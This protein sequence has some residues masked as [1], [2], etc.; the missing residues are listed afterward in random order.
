MDGGSDIVALAGIDGAEERQRLPMIAADTLIR[1]PRLARPLAAMARARQIEPSSASR[2]ARALM[3][4]GLP[5]PAARITTAALV[6]FPEDAS[7]RRD[8]LKQLADAGDP[9][10]LAKFVDSMVAARSRDV[11]LLWRMWCLAEA[12]PAR[13]ARIRAWFDEAAGYDRQSLLRAAQMAHRA[14]EPEHAFG[15]HTAAIDDPDAT[16]D[17]RRN[18]IVDGTDYAFSSEIWPATIPFI[19]DAAASGALAPGR[20]DVAEAL[21]LAG[22]NPLPLAPMP[23][24]LIDDLMVSCPPS[25]G[26]PPSGGGVLMVA[27]SLGCGGMERVLAT[28][29]CELRRRDRA[30]SLALSAFVPDDPR[31]AF[32]LEQSGMAAD[33]IH[34]LGGPAPVEPVALLP[35]SWRTEGA[36][37]HAIVRRERPRLL[38]AWNDRL[39]I[40]AALAGLRAGCPRLLIHVHHMRPTRDPDEALASQP[41][42]AMLRRLAERSDV[43]LL[44]CAEAA[45]RDYLDWLAMP[46][47]GRMHVIRNGFPQQPAADADARRRARARFGLPEAAPVIASLARFEAVKQ[48]LLWIEAAARIAKVMPATCFL[49]AGDGELLGPAR[50]RAAALGLTKRISFPGRVTDAEAVLAAADLVMM[51]SA[52]EGLPNG[53][54]EGQ[55]A[56]VPLVSFDVGGVAET[57]RPQVTGRLVRA[58]DVAALANA[59]VDWLS[60]PA[61]LAAAGIA[62]RA[63]GAAAF[64]VDRYVTELEQLYDEML[65]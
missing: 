37:L 14:G 13:A 62:A 34:R 3:A 63:H 42:P 56:G 47:N 58:N 25:V 31:R 39:G 41:Y 6:A 11:E 48:P 45:K 28:S 17:E 21:A 53:A 19:R 4:A 52:S 40:I 35:A 32:F 8:R 44:F 36:A 49:M 15:R 20:A 5:T 54:V 60:R 10:P 43:R 29:L 51:T 12:D 64:G 22:R 23:Q 57:I 55:M 1:R 50:E 16:P 27:N 33:A 2:I 46:D 26:P 59:A 7:L 30:V 24:V 65:R 9:K 18:A 38:H 61:D